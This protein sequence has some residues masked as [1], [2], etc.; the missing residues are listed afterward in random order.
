MHRKAW[1][2]K[3][4]CRNLAGNRAVTGFAKAAGT[5]LRQMPDSPA[6]TIGKGSGKS[7]APSTHVTTPDGPPAFGAGGKG[8]RGVPFPS[9]AHTGHRGGAVGLLGGFGSDKTPKRT[10]RAIW[11]PRKALWAPFVVR[12][13][14]I[15]WSAMDGPEAEMGLMWGLRGRGLQEN[16]W[17]S[18]GTAG[19][20]TLGRYFRV[21]FRIELTMRIP[22]YTLRV[23]TSALAMPF[24]LID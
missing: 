14:I 4:P 20:M 24:F 12:T 15:C 1:K 8:R 21:E 16:A 18:A 2:R 3:N 19:G 10:R 9:R 6:G 17:I 5:S 7:G 11:M 23:A 13:P 22:L